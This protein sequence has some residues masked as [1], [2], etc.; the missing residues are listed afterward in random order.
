M[1]SRLD[2]LFVLNLFYEDC[3]YSLPSWMN[4]TR[5]T[6]TFSKY[7]DS[8][9]F[10]GSYYIMASDIRS[11]KRNF[12]WT[13]E[14][15][16]Q[17]LFLLFIC[18]WQHVKYYFTLYDFSLHH[19][20]LRISLFCKKPTHVKIRKREIRLQRFHHKGYIILCRLNSIQFNKTTRNCEQ[21]SV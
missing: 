6:L 14:N 10:L 16:L 11:R 7:L 5:S 8:I 15:P 19:H 20:H 2:H 18:T 3:Y 4:R 13:R 17:Q 1:Q 21:K 12:E 9:G